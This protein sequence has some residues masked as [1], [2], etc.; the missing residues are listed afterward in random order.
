MAIDQYW[1]SEQIFFGINKSWEQ[2]MLI[3]LQKNVMYILDIDSNCNL[4]KLTVE[5]FV[6]GTRGGDPVQP[7]RLPPRLSR[8]H[9]RRRWCRGGGTRLSGR[10]SVVVVL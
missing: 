6:C 3:I 2:L 7:T 1:S 9:G 10:P 8:Y 5:Q 4:N